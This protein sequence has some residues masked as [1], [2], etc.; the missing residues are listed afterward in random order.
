[1][2]YNIQVPSILTINA[3]KSHFHWKFVSVIWRRNCYVDWCIVYDTWDAS[4]WNWSTNSGWAIILGLT[5]R[6]YI[7]VTYKRILV[8]FEVPTAWHP[9]TLYN[10]ISATAGIT[11]NLLSWTVMTI[12]VS[13]HALFHAVDF[14]ANITVSSRAIICNRPYGLISSLRFLFWKSSDFYML[15]KS[16]L[17]IWK[18]KRFHHVNE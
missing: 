1:M 18:S 3:E 14:S 10:D 11:K 9:H 12:T 5:E 7:S 2:F 4:R 13:E 8:G 15:R 16:A 17:W 6:H